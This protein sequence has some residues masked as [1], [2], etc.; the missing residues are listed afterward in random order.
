MADQDQQQFLATES[1]KEQSTTESVG[2]NVKK[3]P[4]KA[5]Q[6]GSKIIRLAGDRVMK[7]YPLTE[8]DMRDLTKT[9]ILTSLSFSITG[10]CIGFLVDVSKDMAFSENIKPEIIGF[11]SGIWWCVLVAAIISFLFGAYQLRSGKHRLSEIMEETEHVD[12]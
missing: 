6:R 2:A 8:G 3:R 4:R 12:E 5:S 10:F 11:W 9:G 7:E 1:Q